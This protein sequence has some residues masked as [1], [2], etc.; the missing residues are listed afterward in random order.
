MTVEPATSAADVEHKGEVY[1]FCAKGC[2]E[3]FG[4]SWRRFLEKQGPA[5]ADPKRVS[6]TVLTSLPILSGAPVGAKDPVC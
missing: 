3:V 6:N 2:A 1:Y 5:P 4:E